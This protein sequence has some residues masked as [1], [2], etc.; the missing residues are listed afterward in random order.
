MRRLSVALLVVF[1]VFST[2]PVLSQHKKANRADRPDST[3]VSHDVNEQG[4]S[5]LQKNSYRIDFSDYKNGS[6]YER[7]E[8]EGFKF[9][10]GAKDRRKLELTVDE[11]ALILEAKTRLRAF[12][13]NDSLEPRNYSRVKVTWGVVKYPRG[14]SYEAEVNNE[15]IQVLIFFGHEK[16]SSGHLVLPNS[17]Y[18]IGLFLGRHDMPYKAYKGRYYHQ[19]GR[20]VCMGNPLPGET[21][22]SELDLHHAFKRYFKRDEVPS[23]TGVALAMDT[24]L[25]GDD[26]RAVAFVDRIELFE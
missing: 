23:I 25:S 18:F 13:V 6:I 21:V 19:G 22:I 15:A 10:H 17:P 14:A 26:G 12:I 9:E 7:L 16:I 24:T 8:E 2:S 5:S 1:I 11:G 4:N 20:F 3:I